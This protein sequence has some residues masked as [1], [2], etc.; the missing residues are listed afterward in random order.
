MARRDLRLA[1]GKIGPG[2]FTDFPLS[3]QVPG[4]PGD[5]LTFNAIQ[6]YS[7][8]E[9]ALGTRRSDRHLT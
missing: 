3:V 5:K 9:V 4:K 1:E 7:N 2:Q 8:G 6:T